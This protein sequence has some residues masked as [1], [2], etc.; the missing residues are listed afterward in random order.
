MIGNSI[1]WRFI[2]PIVD[3]GFYE[4]EIVEHLGTLHRARR[5]A[6]NAKLS[7][8]EHALAEICRQGSLM[9]NVQYPALPRYY[10]GELVEGQYTIVSEL[11]EGRPFIESGARGGYQG[12]LDWCDNV[13]KLVEELTPLEGINVDFSRVRSNQ[14]VVSNRGRIKF[15]TTWP[16][17]NVQRERLGASPFLARL[18]SSP[19]GG[20]FVSDGPVDM[21]TAMEN[22]QGILYHLAI[23]SE[24]RTVESALED[25][26]K[27]MARTGATE[28]PAVMGVESAIAELILSL[29]RPDGS[30]EIQSLPALATS[31]RKLKKR[32][33]QRIEEDR[34]GKRAAATGQSSANF[35]KVVESPEPQGSG[36]SGMESSGP[37]FPTAPSSAMAVARDM[38]AAPPPSSDSKPKPRVTAIDATPEEQKPQYVRVKEEIELDTAEA[39]YPKRPDMVSTSEGVEVKIKELPK[40]KSRKAEGI[41]NMVL[42]LIGVAILIGGGIKLYQASRT[43]PNDAPIAIISSAP[44]KIA[45]IEKVVFDAA[46]SSDPENKPLTYHWRVI[47]PENV[48]CVFRPNDTA[49]AIQTNVQFFQG[50]T[51]TVQL[52]VFDGALFSEPVTT[53]VE[54]TGR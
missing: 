7:K 8:D 19:N 15:T 43:V 46:G 48:D 17:G 6:F 10:G 29:R 34:S 2:E 9:G 18:V 30:R 5:R 24:A 14:I 1:C 26:R 37:F 27:E 45:G 11:I 31:A 13:I 52:R 23:G 22:L 42:V 49:A 51:M 12:I 44:T 32:T 20:L 35:G 28:L 50:G 21:I 54:V 4:D 16:V 41:R 38:A 39:L 36:R 25:D 47:D 53:V 33:Q 3:T 40:A